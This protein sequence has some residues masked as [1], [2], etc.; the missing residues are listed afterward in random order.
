[1]KQGHDGTDED[2]GRRGMKQTDFGR[3]AQGQDFISAE[4]IERNSL[5][6]IL[7]YTLPCLHRPSLINFQKLLINIHSL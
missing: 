4:T 5:D 6:Y 3:L 1:L 2:T 7:A